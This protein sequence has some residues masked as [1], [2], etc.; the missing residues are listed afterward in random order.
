M[1]DLLRLIHRPVLPYEG[2]D[3][4]TFSLS[5]LRRIRFSVRGLVYEVS[6]RGIHIQYPQ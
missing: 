3:P 5:L 4:L 1:S 6:V 2:S